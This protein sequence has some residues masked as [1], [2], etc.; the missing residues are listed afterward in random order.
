[1]NEGNINPDNFTDEEKQVVLAKWNGGEL[2]L[3]KLLKRKSDR[4]MRTLVNYK[5][6]KFLE[7]DIENVSVV[8]LIIRD[9]AEQDIDE[10]DFVTKMVREFE[11]NKLF[12]L[13]EKRATDRVPEVTDE[14]AYG[15]YQ[16]N[17]EKFMKP[18]EIELWEIFV[19]D[20]QLAQKIKNELDKGAGF[21]SLAHQYSEDRSIRDR[22]G[23]LG[24]RSQGARGAVSRDA[25]IKGPGNKIGG[26][27]K[28]RNGWVVYKTGE[29][30]QQEVR[31]FKNVQNRAKSLM[32]RE[33]LRE[34]R[35]SWMDELKSKYPVEFNDDLIRSI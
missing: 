28:Y 26:P 9:A 35:V 10:D 6:P 5:N 33:R 34:M 1:M 15:Y 17:P 23:Y 20:E 25:F 7:K 24:Y 11:E 12:Q 21:K 18:A 32:R 14:E 13:I 31:E 2:N 16:K 4:Q 19:K 8:N 3:E 30:R 27:V 29:L 22:G